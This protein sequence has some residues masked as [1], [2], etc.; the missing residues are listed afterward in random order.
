[1]RGEWECL[2]GVDHRGD[3]GAADGVGHGDD[4]GRGPRKGAGLFKRLVQMVQIQTASCCRDQHFLSGAIVCYDRN[5]VPELDLRD[6][7]LKWMQ[8]YGS[9]ARDR[10]LS[11][12]ESA[13][14]PSVRL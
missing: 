8:E 5:V 4:P 11:V 13:A 14:R 2:A 12:I 1:L 7:T 9:S 6:N 10:F 3:G